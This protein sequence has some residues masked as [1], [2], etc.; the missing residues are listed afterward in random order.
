MGVWANLYFE[1][2]G[3]GFGET[4]FCR[5]SARRC[6]SARSG[7]SSSWG[8]ISTTAFCVMLDINEGV[9][10]SSGGECQELALGFG[11]IEDDDG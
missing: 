7:G 9:E 6:W 1:K 5:L 2:S 8:H 10:C 11:I 4:K 3:G